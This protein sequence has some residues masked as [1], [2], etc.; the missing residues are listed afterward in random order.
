M[1][2]SLG[3]FGF[4]A[5]GVLKRFRRSLLRLEEGWWE[6]LTRHLFYT[7]SRLEDSGA[8]GDDESYERGK[9]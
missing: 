2:L 5:S 6:Y 9:R 7:E 4:G 8:L 1:V 3:K